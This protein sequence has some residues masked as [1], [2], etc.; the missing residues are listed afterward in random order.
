MLAF[1]AEYPTLSLPVSNLP[2][3]LAATY[4]FLQLSFKITYEWIDIFTI[5]PGGSSVVDSEVLHDMA[6]V[7]GLLASKRPVNIFKEQ[8]RIVWIQIACNTAFTFPPPNKEV[9]KIS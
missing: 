3:D 7:S 9:Y 5:Y 2:S 1:R 6:L 4:H 8:G